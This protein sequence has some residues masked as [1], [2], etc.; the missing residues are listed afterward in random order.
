MAENGAEV[1]AN[2]PEEFTRRLREDYARWVRIR[3]E[4]GIKID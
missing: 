1:V 3:K 4:T 2:S